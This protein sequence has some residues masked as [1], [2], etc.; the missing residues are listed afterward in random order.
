[1]HFTMDQRSTVKEENPDMSN[2]EVTKELGRRWREMG[3]EEKEPYQTAS[4]EQKAAYDEAMA[5]YTPPPSDGE[6]E[7]PKKGRKK[8]R[9]EGAPKKA[10]NAYMHFTMAQRETVKA[11]NSEMSNTEVTKEL[12]RL[13]REEMNE[14]AKAPFIQAAAEDKQRY[15][16]EME[17]YNPSEAS[18]PAA[19]KAPAKKPAQKKSPTPK[20]APKSPAKEKSPAKKAPAKKAP[21]KKSPAKK[22]PAKKT[23]EEQQLEEAYAAF[24]EVESEA[25][26]EERADAE[27]EPF[28]AAEMEEYLKD[29]WADLS[30]ADRMEYLE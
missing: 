3:D 9:D 29:L 7:S 28:S 4:D 10:L 1:M 12:G 21:A 22:A 24:V 23:A 27:E 25:A 17:T 16:R 19:K 5:S 8:K 14:E 13:W 20:P 2:T 11:D 26:A 6:S 30:P 15:A 18:P